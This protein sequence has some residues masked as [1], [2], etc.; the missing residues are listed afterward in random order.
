VCSTIRATRRAKSK[1]ARN[2]AS[3][4]FLFADLWADK[5]DCCL[6][7]SDQSRQATISASPY[8]CMDTTCSLQNC[9][10]RETV[11]F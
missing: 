6:S 8:T 2:K 9:A 7:S 1:E 4:V 3:R 5:Q 10:R 11:G